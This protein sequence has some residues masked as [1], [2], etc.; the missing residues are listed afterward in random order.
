MAKLILF[1][2]KSRGGIWCQLLTFIDDMSSVADWVFR[3]HL[4]NKKPKQTVA[5]RAPTFCAN[6]Y[7]LRERALLNN[8]KKSEIALFLLNFVSFLMLAGAR[9]KSKPKH[10]PLEFA[11][12]DHFAGSSA[13]AQTIFIEFSVRESARVTLSF[14]AGATAARKKRSGWKSG[15]KVASPPQRAPAST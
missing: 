4:S 13:G 15:E 7:I 3:C 9:E 2:H 11:L 1:E 10:P 5:G 14:A 8:E 12:R 6:R